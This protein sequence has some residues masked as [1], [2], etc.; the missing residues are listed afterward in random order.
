MKRETVAAVAWVAALVA[1]AV[2]A[3]VVGIRN[4]GR[5]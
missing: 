4:G 2:A 3:I 5:R 1:A